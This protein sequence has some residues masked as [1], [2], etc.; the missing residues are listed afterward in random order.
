MSTFPAHWDERTVDLAIEEVTC[1]LAPREL[2]ELLGRIDRSELADLERSVAALDLATIDEFEAPP[3]SLVAELEVDARRFAVGAAPEAARSA[4][5][6]LPGW[7]TWGGW[8]AAA[9]VLAL[10]GLRAAFRREPDATQ[11]RDLLVAD[12]RD[13]VRATWKAT[14]DPLAG[15]VSGE[16]VWS[17]T[18][19][20]G[21]MSFRGL[22]AND[23]HAHQY[24]LWIFDAKRA[25]WEAKPVDGG[26]FDV[27][28]NTE[29]VV[30]IDAK[31]SVREPK[32]FAVTLEV[33][34]GVVVSQREHLLATA[35]P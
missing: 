30:P 7:I 26:V 4:R 16:V 8:A 11:R 35:S 13:L 25:E 22:P 28:A 15:G 12:A 9:A 18:R 19:Q 10:F 23:P 6:G 1:G 29:V 21:Y 34:G 20:E 33:P 2:E 3:A 31:L 32:L 14:E 5:P 17:S 27:A 24:Q